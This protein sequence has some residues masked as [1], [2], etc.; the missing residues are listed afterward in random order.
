MGKRL[1]S[2]DRFRGLCIVC[3]LCQGLFGVFEE[4]FESWS[5][6]FEHGEDGFQI[7]PGVAFADIFAPCFIFIVG[8]TF[9]RSFLSRQEKVGT[10]K[11]YVHLGT[12][13]LAIIGVG[14]ILSGLDKFLGIIEDLLNEGLLTFSLILDGI[15]NN[16]HLNVKIS[17][18][19]FI[20]FVLLLIINLIIKLTQ[21]KEISNK[22]SNIIRYY[23]TII[24]LFNLYSICAWHGENVEKFYT[25]SYTDGEARLGW[26]IGTKLWDTLQ[27]IGLAGLLALPFVSFKKEGKL[28]IVI[29]ILFITTPFVN[30]GAILMTSQAI[31]GGLFGGFGWV[32]ILLLGSIFYDLR[33]EKNIKEYWLLVLALIVFALIGIYGINMPAA[34]RGCTPVY[35]TVTA[36]IAACIFALFEQFNNKECKC[37]ILKIFGEN[38]LIIYSINYILAVVLSIIFTSIGFSPSIPVGLVLIVVFVGLYFIPNYILYKKDIHIKF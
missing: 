32:V 8:L 14:G 31:E 2:I 12:R 16:K 26:S 34:K 3:M 29:A 15:N 17:I 21:N 25:L 24:G 10:K 22:F 28:A 13:F 1:L 7:L 19:S 33:V 5:L 30:H 9:T 38:G 6:L 20:I 27:N 4:T 18:Y 23:V 11:A 36:A 35:A 37:D